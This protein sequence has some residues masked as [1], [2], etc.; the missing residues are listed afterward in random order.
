MKFV[1][2][3]DEFWFSLAAFHAIIIMSFHSVEVASA[4]KGT[5]KM[6]NKL[7]TNYPERVRRERESRE[8]HECMKTV[9][10]KLGLWVGK[11]GYKSYA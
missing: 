7:A 9:A 10:R 8:E 1:D 6:R 4:Q 11:E 3:E 2:A 5:K